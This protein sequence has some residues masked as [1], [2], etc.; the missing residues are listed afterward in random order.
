MV[1]TRVKISV[2]FFSALFAVLSGVAVAQETASQEPPAQKQLVPEKYKDWS[3]LCETP[4][5]LDQEI[6]YI[7]QNIT[8]KDTGQVI[9]NINIH[10]P[11]NLDKA[12]MVVTL[13]MG[14]ALVPGIRVQVDEGEAVGV[15]YSVCLNNGCRA[16]FPLEEKMLAALKKGSKL[17]IT[18]ASL[19]GKGTKFTTSL[20][21]F[22][23]AVAALKR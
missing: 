1:S 4:K 10:Y 19:Q 12:A 14:V 15:P 13:P 9:M 16:G 5:G 18:F 3:K 11:E 22:T 21:G 23:A 7:F 8:V 20:S 6:C 17:N 2:L